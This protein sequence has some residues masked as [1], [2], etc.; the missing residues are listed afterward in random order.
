MQTR[1]QA[2]Q[3][4]G[5]GKKI[6]AQLEEL[7]SLENRLNLKF[8]TFL[9]ELEEKRNLSVSVAHRHQ[10]EKVEEIEKLHK[11]LSEEVQEIKIKAEDKAIIQGF[12]GKVSKAIEKI[13]KSLK[14][15]NLSIYV[16]IG[17]FLLL[18]CSALFFWQ[19]MKTKQ[20]IISDYLAEQ[21][22]QGKILTP[23]LHTQFFNEVDQWFIENPNNFKAFAKWREKKEKK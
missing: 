9:Q 14:V 10:I 22:K 2:E 5:L 4:L 3:N 8:D 19:S 13:N 21:E 7:K 18:L 17:S 6:N 16:L 12:D 15:P 1:E 23:K 20:D 11:L